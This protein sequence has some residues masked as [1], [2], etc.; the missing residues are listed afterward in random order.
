MKPTAT[1]YER[2]SRAIEF[3]ATRAGAQP[4]LEEA[5]AAAGLSPHHF[6]RVFS[7]WV[8]I[9]PKRFLQVVTVERAKALLAAREPTLAVA[10]TVGLS[11]GSR[12]HDH[13]VALEAVSPGQFS[14]AGT[15]LTIRHGLAESPFGRVF[16]ASTA[17]G[18]CRLAFID[19]DAETR[20]AEIESGLAAD[21]PHATL[22]R[23][24]AGARA[25][26]QRV[27]GDAR[28]RAAPLSLQVRGTNFQVAVWRALLA[29]PAG[30]VTT[31]ADLAA[32]IGRPGAARAVGSAIG[33]NR[34]AWLI[35]CHR[36][37]RGTGELGG[38]RWGE[39]RKRAMLTWEATRCA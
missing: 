20:V 39:P 28:A 25:S 38:Y 11:S 15:G 21:W 29:I 5:A 6:Q 34:I 10:D 37:I 8:G 27:F 33:A 1:D 2:M 12:L 26:T 22:L 13:F 24:D 35:P 17:R 7:R 14:A 3:L 32:R 18:I 36:V 23:D 16:V 31:Y 4:G 19:A 9:S 30:E